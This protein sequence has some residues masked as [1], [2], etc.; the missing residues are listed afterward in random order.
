MTSKSKKKK[1][2]QTNKQ[3]NKKLNQLS[4]NYHNATKQ[5]WHI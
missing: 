5:D 1:E 2:Q 3:T 4:Q